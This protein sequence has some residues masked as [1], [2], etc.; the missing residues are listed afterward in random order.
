VPDEDGAF[1]LSGEKRTASRG[2]KGKGKRKKGTD[3]Q[4]WGGGR[5][6][7]HGERIFVTGALC[8]SV[9]LS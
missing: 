5:K 7:G 4:E 3:G 2:E 6:V 1:F 9:T 8:S